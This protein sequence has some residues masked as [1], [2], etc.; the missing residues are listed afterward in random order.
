MDHL[1]GSSLNVSKLQNIMG[2]LGNWYSLSKE[3]GNTWIFLG[4][5]LTVFRDL[6]HDP[7]SGAQP[8]CTTAV[9]WGKILMK[10]TMA[11]NCPIFTITATSMSSIMGRNPILKKNSNCDTL[12]WFTRY[13]ILR[14]N[15]T[16]Q[17]DQMFLPRGHKQPKLHSRLR[18]YFYS[19]L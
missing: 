19:N 2:I 7:S 17:S 12:L 13:F 3:F 10:M 9:W 15:E 14:P 6:F 8:K 1:Q 18:H 16:D 4:A 5:I 11:L